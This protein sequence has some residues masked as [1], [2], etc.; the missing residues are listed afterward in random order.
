MKRRK[1]PVMNSHVLSCRMGQGWTWEGV[2]DLLHRQSLLLPHA[3]GLHPSPP[4]PSPTLEPQHGPVGE[5]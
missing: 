5:D 4:S 1:S 2:Q 3:V